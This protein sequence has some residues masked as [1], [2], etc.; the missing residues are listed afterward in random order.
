M[1]ARVPGR[2]L[3]RVR[4][5][6]LLQRGRSRATI[7]ENGLNAQQMLGHPR[8]VARPIVTSTA[9]PYLRSLS[10]FGTQSP[11]M[12]S[13]FFGPRPSVLQFQES[14][15]WRTFATSGKKDYYGLLGVSSTATL[16][17]I[18]KAYL[19]KAKQFHPDLNPAPDAKVKFQE[20]GEAYSVL[21]DSV[22]RRRYDQ[23]QHDS[24]QTYDRSSYSSSSSSTSA[25]HHSFGCFVATFD[26]NAAQG[27]TSHLHVFAL[28]N[29]TTCHRRRSIL[30]GLE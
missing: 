29:K 10:G 15:Q 16:D 18:K 4:W 30:G 28:S 5:P 19:K 23:G 22:T 3:A 21:K 24:Q 1:L 9:L 27:L 2:S 8:S 17:E 20:I 14:Y 11:P 12:R 7:I 26:W 6:L 25:Q 13:L